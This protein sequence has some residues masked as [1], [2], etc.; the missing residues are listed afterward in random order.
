MNGAPRRPGME[1]GQVEQWVG[2]VCRSLGVP[3]EDPGDDFFAAG[4]T[5]LTAIRL[6]AQ[7]EAEYG[8]DCLPPDDIYESSTIRGIAAAIVRNSTTLVHSEG[9]R[10]NG[11]D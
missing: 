10:G 4:A 6:M 3:V 5:S 7:A 8:E 1:P 2:D 11:Q 9:T